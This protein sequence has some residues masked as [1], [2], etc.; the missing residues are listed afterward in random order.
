MDGADDDNTYLA[1]YPEVDDEV[2]DPSDVED[3][4]EAMYDGDVIV[5]A[6]STIKR[7]NPLLLGSRMG[8]IFSS[9][10][11]TYVFSAEKSKKSDVWVTY[12]IQPDQ[13]FLTASPES[14][15][16]YSFS[17]LGA[18]TLL[19][20]SAEDGVVRCDFTLEPVENSQLIMGSRWI[21]KW[22]NSGLFEVRK[23]SLW[24]W[25]TYMVSQA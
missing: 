2:D 14:Y 7:G 6:D 5:I 9:D 4:V 8:M 16:D 3:V 20:A 13:T 24:E 21:G 11:A 10:N 15:S 17:P 18:D 25:P 12:C 22:M 23:T 1:L 19:I